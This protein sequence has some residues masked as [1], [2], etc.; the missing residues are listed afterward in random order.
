MKKIL[1][2]ALCAATLLMT[3]CSGDTSITVQENTILLNSADISVSVPDAWT[4]TSGEALY[5]EM[6]P[7]KGYSDV[8]GMIEDHESMG[9]T[10]YA[11][12]CN[13][14]NTAMAVISSQNI[15]PESAD[16]EQIT[17]AD[18][19]RSV[20]D[21]TIFDYLASDYKTGKDSSFSETNIGGIDGYLSYFEVFTKDEEPAFA[22]GFSEFFFQRDELIYTIQVCYFDQN[23]KEDALS[24]INNITT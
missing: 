21:S 9:F 2:C 23:A 19:A 5:E 12:T 18:Y 24:V 15:T 1:I 10:Y 20:H 17:L 6:L 13:S 7:L 8:N 11:R 4:V 16:D 3:A 22:L 14:A